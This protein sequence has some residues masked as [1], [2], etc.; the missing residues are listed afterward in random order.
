MALSRRV[1]GTGAPEM[2]QKIRND[3][4]R[5]AAAPRFTPSPS[6]SRSERGAQSRRGLEHLIEV[7]A[8][9]TKRELASLARGMRG[10]AG[11]RAAAGAVLAPVAG[12]HRVRT[13]VAL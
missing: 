6:A 4:R 7:G 5:C 9:G 13:L 10:V 1:C 8:N 3:A 12:G 11:V 2:R